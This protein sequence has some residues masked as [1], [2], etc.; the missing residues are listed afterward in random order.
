MNLSD[1][2]MNAVCGGGIAGWTP[3]ERP[4]GRQE[5]PAWVRDA[6]V[7]WMHGASNAPSV[8]LKVVGNVRSWESQTWVKEGSDCYIARHADGRAKVLYHGG[9]VTPA[10]AWRVFAGEK[11]FTY[12][13]AVPERRQAGETWEDAA[14]REGAAHLASIQAP[15]PYPLHDPHSGKPLDRA[16]CRVV[17]RA[18]NVTTQQS[19]FGGD[20]YA[21]D[22]ADGSRMLLRGPWHGGAPAGYV[23]VGLLDVTSPYYRPYP[24]QKPR[25]WYRRGGTVGY[26]TEDLFLRIVSTYCA[27]VPVA[28]VQHRYGTRIEPYRAEW[29]MP[30]AQIYDIEWKRA[31]QKEPA[32][33]FW[34][35]YWDGRERY[36]GSLRIPTH[37]FQDAVTDLPTALELL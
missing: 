1:D 29:E 20:G 31:Q 23:E 21:L 17:V 18:F 6:H 8:T 13:W 15:S 28:R 22:M 34:R 26:I 4:T 35:V 10:A 9:A 2:Q 36:C 12:R 33:E 37:G 19:G 30:K 11:P 32:G 27:H 14:Q 3:V 7:D 5:L 25:P 24:G 16:S